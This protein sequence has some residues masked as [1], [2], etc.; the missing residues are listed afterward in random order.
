[1]LGVCWLFL[2]NPDLIFTPGSDG[3]LFV[4][5]NW[6]FILKWNLIVMFSFI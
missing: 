2:D 6:P 4:I 5:P 1:M 3:I